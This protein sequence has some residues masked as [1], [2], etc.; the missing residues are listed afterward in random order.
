MAQVIKKLPHG[1]LGPTGICLRHFGCQLDEPSCYS[2]PGD[3]QKNA[4][5]LCAFLVYKVFSVP[6]ALLYF[7]GNKTYYYYYYL[8]YHGCWWS[9]NT[10]S[11]VISIHDNKCMK[12]LKYPSLGSWHQKGWYNELDMYVEWLIIICMAPVP[13]CKVP[14]L[15]SVYISRA[16]FTND[17]SVIIQIQWKFH[18]ALIHVAGKWRLWNF[19]HG[20]TTVLSCHV[21]NFIVMWCMTV[22]LQ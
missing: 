15:H 13:V 14:L 20:M 19:A 9:D 11:Q 12:C 16:H 21:Q 18:S 6:V 4:A 22:E 1:R 3:H 17:F 2:F 7:V 8:Q 5:M 10:R